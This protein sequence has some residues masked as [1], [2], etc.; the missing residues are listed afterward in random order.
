M[1]PN[2]KAKRITTFLTFASGSS[3]D[4]FSPL[5]LDA[6]TT[7]CS[8]SISW[9]R[10][11]LKITTMN[12]C[13]YMLISW[14][15]MRPCQVPLRDGGQATNKLDWRFTN[16]APESS[17]SQACNYSRNLSQRITAERE[18]ALKGAWPA[19]QTVNLN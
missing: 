8:K 5:Q 9:C 16:I 6:L 18:L 3:T 7:F 11:R 4:S 12:S 10:M 14:L 15:E 1:Y 2:A 13:T 19:R 17:E